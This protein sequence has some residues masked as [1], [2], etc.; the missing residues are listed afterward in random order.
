[1]MEIC[2]DQKLIILRRKKNYNH[3]NLVDALDYKQ[4]LTILELLYFYQI[5]LSIKYYII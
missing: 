1:M 4:K 3:K 2:Y 5:N